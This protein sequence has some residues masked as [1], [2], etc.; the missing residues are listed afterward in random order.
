MT[1]SSDEQ[2]QGRGEAGADAEEEKSRGRGPCGQSAVEEG[3]W[4]DMGLETPC[5]PAIPGHEGDFKRMGIYRRTLGSK[6]CS[7]EWF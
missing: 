1:R 7:D 4:P 5:H 3:G 6:T 2:V